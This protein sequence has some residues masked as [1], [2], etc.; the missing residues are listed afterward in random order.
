MPAHSSPE[1]SQEYQF[2]LLNNFVEVCFVITLLCIKRKV[3]P[4][5]HAIILFGR[6]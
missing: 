5:K 1:T 4:E 6:W 2:F 3:E